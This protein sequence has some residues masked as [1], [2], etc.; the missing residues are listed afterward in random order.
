MAKENT[1]FMGKTTQILKL[2]GLLIVIGG[3][4]ASAFT[5]FAKAKTVA[6]VNHRMELGFSQDDVERKQSMLE[7]AEIQAKFKAKEDPPTDFEEKIL[8]KAEDAF[9]KTQRRHEQRVQQYEQ[10]YEEKAKL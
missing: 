3:S 9:I 7:W 5:Y 10:K 2:V 8:Q 6:K 1:D 4:L